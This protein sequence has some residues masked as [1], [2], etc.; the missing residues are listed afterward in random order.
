MP[1][2]ALAALSPMDKTTM[3]EK[4]PRELRARAVT[5]RHMLFRIS[6]VQTRRAIAEL[7][8]EFDAE[9]DR[10]EAPQPLRDP[11][12]RPKPDIGEA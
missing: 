8:E 2:Y 1:T 6:D 12:A 11:P 5:Y 3:N 10:I 4:D 9:A 7:A